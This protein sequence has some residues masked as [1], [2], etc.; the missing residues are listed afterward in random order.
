MIFLHLIN[1]EKFTNFTISLFKESSNDENLFL[2]CLARSSPKPI[3]TSDVP[4][5]TFVKEGSD[6][7]YKLI[8]ELSFDV[9]FV[10]YLDFYKAR[11]I[12]KLPKEKKVVWMSWGADFYNRK[13]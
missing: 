5:V 11:A 8:Q 1:D 3:Y 7:F 12:L 6:R 9:L 10:H 2:V 13:F 4:N